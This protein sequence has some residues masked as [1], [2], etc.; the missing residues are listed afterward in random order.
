MSQLAFDDDT[1]QRLEAVY[2]IGDAIRRRRLVREA[3]RAAPGE[4]ILD[5]GCGPGFYCA[6]LAEEVGPSGSIVGLDTSAPMLALA[7]RRCESDR[8]VELR[9]GDAGSLPVEHGRFDAAICVQVL[10]YL[11]D[12]TAALAEIRRALRPG[13]RAVVWDVDWATLSVNSRDEARSGR[14]LAAWDEH[15]AH[16]SLPRTLAS[17]LRAA[18]FADVEMQGHLFAT[19]E[20]DPETYGT[21][22]VSV[23][24]AFVAGRDGIG[25]SE[26]E[27]WL[28]EQRALGERGE[29]YFAVSQFCFNAV[30]PA[31]GS[32]TA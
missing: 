31:S 2:R 1:A 22:T 12:A 32:T 8:N 26:A 28:A 23:I 5:V 25:A 21:A 17:R 9:E 14:V 4:R 10:E 6:E 16:R 15:L 30:N 19:A 24:A 3:L 27:A 20:F 11:P 18:G 29:F 13:G 7:A